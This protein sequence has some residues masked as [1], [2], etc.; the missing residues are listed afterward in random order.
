MLFRQFD[1]LSY[2]FIVEGAKMLLNKFSHMHMVQCPKSSVRD[3]NWLLSLFQNF[4]YIPKTVI[5]YICFC[6]VYN[7]EIIAVVLHHIT[8]KN[9]MPF[10]T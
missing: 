3:T 5:T 9:N 4:V 6:M 2:V 8:I 1:N 10:V 7:T